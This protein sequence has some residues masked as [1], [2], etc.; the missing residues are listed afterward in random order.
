MIDLTERHAAQAKA[1]LGAQAF[2]AA[3]GAGRHLGPA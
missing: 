2:R 1:E 3:Y